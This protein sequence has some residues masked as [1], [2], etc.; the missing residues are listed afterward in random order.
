MKRKEEVEG[1]IEDAL[2]LQHVKVALLVYA[3]GVRYAVFQ[4]VLA[5]LVLTLPGMPLSKLEFKLCFNCC[6]FLVSF[7]S[8]GL[9]C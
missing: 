9:N 7:C 5:K 1:F 2:V 4:I 3:L 6:F 8:Y